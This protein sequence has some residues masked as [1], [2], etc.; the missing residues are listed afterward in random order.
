MERERIALVLNA[1]R[2]RRNGGKSDGNTRQ[3]KVPRQGKLA[4]PLS[5][6]REAANLYRISTQFL[7]KDCVF[8]EKE[9]KKAQVL[10]K[11]FSD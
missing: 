1:P 6:V 3:Y 2:L 7:Q 4:D 8:F 9:S 11:N 10:Q 5:L